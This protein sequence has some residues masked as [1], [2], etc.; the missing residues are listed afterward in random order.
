MEFQEE[1]ALM[2]ENWEIV[3]SLFPEG[4]ERLA[5]R[6]SA[7]KRLR[8]FN[9]IEE[10]IRT[11]LMHIGMG[12]SLRE[13]VVWAKGAG[14]ATVS[15]VALLKRLRNAEQLFQKLCIKL[16]P[17]E[18]L[19]I[20]DIQHF[21]LVDATIVKEP[22]ATGT[23]WRMHYCIEIPSL[24]CQYFELTKT[25]GENVAEGFNRLPIKE[26]DYIIG[27]RGYSKEKGIIHIDQ[28]K[29]KV[30]VRVHPKN[31]P[32]YNKDGEKFDL[33]GHLSVLEKTGSIGE[34]EVTLRCG[35]KGYI[36]ALR[37][38]EHAIKKA[39]HNIMQKVRQNGTKTQD[40]TTLEYAKYV[41]VFTTF[42][43]DKFKAQDVLE[44]YRKRWQIELI[45]KRFKSL[46]EFGH[47][48]K[49]DDR[50]VRAWLYGKL[51]LA[52][53]AQKF[54]SIARDFSPWGYPNIWKSETAL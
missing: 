13:T 35:I 28:Y 43:R 11:L 54:V 46:A 49:Y 34:W 23:Q 15:D 1:N 42:P 39:I 19:K 48:P 27:D 12:L 25:Q 20:K 32:L 3:K 26:G 30:L 41:I 5:K 45:F 6:T 14:I 2:S 9:G 50:S 38:S 22:G 36:Y 24:T 40:K 51:F 16:M 18:Q 37:K 31:L 8:G 29:G 21:K 44:I 7:V 10:L 47:I 4:W 33:L 17:K 53:L 52:L